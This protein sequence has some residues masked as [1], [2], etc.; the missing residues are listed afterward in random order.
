MK[1]VPAI[2]QV[3]LPVMVL[4]HLPDG[5]LYSELHGALFALS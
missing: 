2:P 3:F 1:G 4:V 5:S